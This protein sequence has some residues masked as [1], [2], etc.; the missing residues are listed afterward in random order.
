MQQLVAQRDAELQ[1]KELTEQM[2]L[3]IVE[4]YNKKIDDLSKQHENLRLESKNNF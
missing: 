3:A 1:Q 2:K 4:K